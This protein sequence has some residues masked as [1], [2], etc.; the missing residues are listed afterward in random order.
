MTSQLLLSLNESTQRKRRRSIECIRMIWHPSK[1]AYSRAPT[2][3]WISLN[4]K[5]RHRRN[6]KTSS[7]RSKRR[8][9]MRQILA[10]Q[11]FSRKSQT[12]PIKMKVGEKKSL[13]LTKSYRTRWI[14]ISTLRASQPKKC[15]SFSKSAIRKMSSTTCTKKCSKGCRRDLARGSWASTRFW[16]RSSTCWTLKVPAAPCTASIQRTDL[17]T[18]STPVST[19]AVQ[20]STTA[21]SLPMDCKRRL[22]KTYRHVKSKRRTRRIWQ[23]QWSIGCRATRNW[24][25]TLIK[26]KMKLKLSSS[27]LFD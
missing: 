26:S 3:T 12:I 10:N 25:S 24:S 18:R 5:E 17:L 9:T 16:T 6:P 14:W 13:R 11:P 15:V 27:T 2:T 20:A 19:F 21:E 7:T 22:R 4:K 23:T 1:E 8:R